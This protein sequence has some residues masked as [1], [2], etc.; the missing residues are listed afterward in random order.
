V[1]FVE[2]LAQAFRPTVQVVLARHRALSQR[3]S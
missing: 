3:A 1:Y 2:T